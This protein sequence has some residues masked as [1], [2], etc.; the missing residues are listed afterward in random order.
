[1]RRAFSVAVY[2]RRG[3]EG[4]RV[5]VIHHRRLETWLP[6]GG[7]IEDGETP[8]EAARRE[9]REETGLEGAFLPLADAF[10]GV[11]PGYL[12]YEEHVAGSKG[13]HM[14]F[15]FVA[16]VADD[17]EVTPNHEFS[18]F[19]WVDSAALEQL[20]APRNAVQF[21]LAALRAR[22]R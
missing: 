11:P 8:L 17:A 6:I 15:V 10:E 18:E 12:G 2:A 3:G 21:G 14:N 9:L 20:S 5:L 7:E 16:D 19:R 13:L 1:M 4:G 22:A